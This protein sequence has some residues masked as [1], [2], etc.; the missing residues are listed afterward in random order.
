MDTRPIA[1]SVAPNLGH[2]DAHAAIRRLTDV[3]GFEVAALF[4]EPDGAVAHAQLVWGTGAINIASREEAPPR[5]PETGPIAVAL[6]ADDADAVDRYYDRA[7]A[8]G[9]EVLLPVEDTF[10]SNHRFTVQNSEGNRWNV[11]IPWID[12]EAARRLPR[13]VK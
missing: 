9:A 7:L 2:R 4:E 13:R 3:L 12:S 1:P 6:T 8:A 11:G 5:L 10:T